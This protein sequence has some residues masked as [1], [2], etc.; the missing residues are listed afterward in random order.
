MGYSQELREF[1]HG[2]VRGGRTHFLAAK[3]ST[4]KYYIKVGVDENNRNK[5]V[6]QVKLQSRVMWPVVCRSH[7]LSA[8]TAATDL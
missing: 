4:F 8:K 1:Q 2:P 5:V 3:Y 7:Q 6:A